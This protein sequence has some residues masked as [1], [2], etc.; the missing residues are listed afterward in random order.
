[1][2]CIKPHMLV[3]S[4][5]P[6][7]VTKV[8]DTPY[9]ANKIFVGFVMALVLVFVIKGCDAFQLCISIR[10]SLWSELE[11]VNVSLPEMAIDI[12][13]HMLVCRQC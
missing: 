7:S 8:S 2:I 13:F 1:M 12:L 10:L 3:N 11:I 4:V 6:L 5:S 9:L